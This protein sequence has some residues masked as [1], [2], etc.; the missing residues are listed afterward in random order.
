MH[1]VVIYIIQ[2]PLHVSISLKCC[3][4]RYPQSRCVSHHGRTIVWSESEVT[5][6]R[7]IK[8]CSHWKYKLPY[9]KNC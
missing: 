3:V 4:S 5:Y 1:R 7:G 2:F 9:N 8:S 6:R